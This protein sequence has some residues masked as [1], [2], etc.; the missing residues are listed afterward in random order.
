HPPVAFGPMAS[1][2]DP[3]RKREA[4]VEVAMRHFAE[5][6]Y[7]GARGEDSATEF[8]VARGTVFLH[9]GSKEG[10]FLATFEKA[11][12][13]LPAWLDAPEDVRDAG[14]WAVLGYWLAPPRG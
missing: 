7:R 9:F 6:G 1:E 2:A 4:I 10:L 14:F 5:H 12:R 8:G 3:Q 13:E 11:V